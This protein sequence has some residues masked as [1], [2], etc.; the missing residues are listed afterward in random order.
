MSPAHI[1]GLVLATAA[2]AAVLVA[3]HYLVRYI[4]A[5]HGWRWPPQWNYALGLVSAAG[6]I[7]LA[8][9]LIRLPMDLVTAA[10][11]L[12]CMCLAG[13]PDFL[14][15]FSEQAAA[16]AARRRALGRL[17]ET[18]REL[19]AEL[20]LLKLAGSGRHYTRAHDLVEGIQF[21][22]GEMHRN[23]DDIQMLSDQLRPLLEAL[24]VGQEA[25][26]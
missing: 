12:F 26:E 9:G 13:V 19:A 15:H 22:L 5:T 21:I 3:E 6:G 2:V 10:T 14:L 16:R 23:R 1:T 4:E 24:L 17:A 8:A 11:L 25:G 20:A 18:N 7:L